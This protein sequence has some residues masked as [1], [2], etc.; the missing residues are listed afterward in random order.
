MLCKR[1]AVKNFVDALQQLT[2]PEM[3]FKVLSSVMNDQSCYL[4]GLG[5]YCM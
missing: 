3:I 2:N 1:G 5:L 4:L